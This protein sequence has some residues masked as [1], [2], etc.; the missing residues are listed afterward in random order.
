M[1]TEVFGFGQWNK[2]GYE[3]LEPVIGK[4]NDEQYGIGMALL[5]IVVILVPVMLCT[6]PIMY[7]CLHN[8]ADDEQDEI[9][10][11]NINRGDDMS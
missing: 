5:F 9:E 1:I 10:F 2:T 11:T 7:A 3:N 6:K 8:D 4:T